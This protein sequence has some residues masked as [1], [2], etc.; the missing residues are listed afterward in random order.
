MGF[1]GLVCSNFQITG[2]MVLG[3]PEMN[4]GPTSA[5]LGRTRTRDGEGK[6]ERSRR[7]E[8]SVNSSGLA[9]APHQTSAASQT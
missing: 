7:L 6:R 8:R 2:P 4:V 3:H 9:T 5:A 1:P